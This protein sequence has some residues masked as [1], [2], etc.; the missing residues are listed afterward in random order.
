MSD[1]ALMYN[2]GFPANVIP[3]VL[4]STGQYFSIRETTV[5]E[6]K[7]ICKVVIN[8]LGTRQMNVIYDEIT[9]Y[10]QSMIVDGDIDVNKITEFDRLYCLLVFFHMSFFKEPINFKCPHCGVDI[11][12]RYDMSRYIYNMEKDAFVPDQ[13]V[14]IPYKSIEFRVVIGWPTVEMMSKLYR[15]FYTQLG[16]VTD[17]MEETQF[18]INLVLTFIKNITIINSMT[19]EVEMVVDSSEFENWGEWLNI[20][21]SVP[22][23]VVF[24]EA[25][26]LFPKIT[27]YFIN[28]LENCFGSELCPQCHEDTYY[29]LSQ[30]NHFY[31]LLYGSLSGML[32]FIMQIE[33][34]LQFRYDTCIF[35]K[36]EWMTYNDLNSF[37]HQ[38][39]V[40]AE[41]DNEQRK[42]TGHDHLYKGLWMI[43]EILNNI[44]FPQDKK[45]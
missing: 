9:K 20:V 14:V 45:Q 15:N 19:S 18:G 13:V 7:S 26:G 17:E 33:V 29:G 30:S 21:N 40:T 4:P 6:L 24:D 25:T 28:R 37:V 36:E 8:N 16:P 5:S 2:K 1:R 35:D 43:R 11:N 27:G 44:V 23:M 42:R 3:L 41:K 38:I 12:Y 31:G 10:L 34:L 32:S 22:S 39:G